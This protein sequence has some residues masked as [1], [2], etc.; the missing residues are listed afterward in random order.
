[1]RYSAV[2]FEGRPVAILIGYGR[3][4]DD[5][6]L[7]FVTDMPAYRAAREYVETYLHHDA[8]AANERVGVDEEIPELSGVYDHRIVTTPKGAQLVPTGL[9]D[10]EGNPILDHAAFREAVERTVMPAVR[11]NNVDHRGPEGL[12]LTAQAIL[13]SL[14]EGVVGTADF[15]PLKR[16]PKAYRKLDWEG[17]LVAS[18]DNCYLVGTTSYGRHGY[19][20]WT[21]AV[22][23][24][25]IG[26]R[27]LYD[28]LA[29]D[30]GTGPRP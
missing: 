27:D 18:G 17:V 5:H 19:L 4:K 21:T 24:E 28:A 22:D 1:M 20:G 3:G 14:G 23:A 11:G 25:R 12:A 16:E 2:T 6:L 7:R 8:E 13:D 30:A 26:G 29:R 15:V 10:P 9:I